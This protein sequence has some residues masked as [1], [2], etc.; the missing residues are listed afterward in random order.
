MPARFLLFVFFVSFVVPPLFAQQTAN[1]LRADNGL[2]KLSDRFADD[3][4]D[5]EKLRQDILTFRRS[6]PGTRQALKAA[7]ML[8]QLP[9]PMD[10]LDPGKIRPLEVFDWQPKEL[11]AILGEHR[12]R[13]G[14]AVTGV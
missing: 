10:A 3:K 12:G 11:V 2:K 9:S 6:F 14:G 5:R 8:R 7:E 4:A 13:Q 1:E